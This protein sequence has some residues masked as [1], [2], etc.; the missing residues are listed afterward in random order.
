MHESCKMIKSHF[1]FSSHCLLCHASFSKWMNLI[2]TIHNIGRVCMHECKLYGFN[3][4]HFRHHFKT[5]PKNTQ[6]QLYRMKKHLPM[7][8]QWYFQVLSKIILC[9]MRWIL[10]VMRRRAVW[11]C[12][13]LLHPDGGATLLPQNQLPTMANASLMNINELTLTLR[14]SFT[15]APG[16]VIAFISEQAFAIVAFARRLA[17]RAAEKSISQ[18]VRRTSRL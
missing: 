7:W 11:H 15:G 8:L 10:V 5:P 14:A 2:A 6:V 4:T 17:R 12:L 16:Y 3:I 9:K 13:Y 1:L 18:S